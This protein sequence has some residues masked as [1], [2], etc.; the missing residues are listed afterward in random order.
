MWI[1]DAGKMVFSVQSIVP[2]ADNV[3]ISILRKQ[4]V[5]RKQFTHDQW[6]NVVVRGD[7]AKDVGVSRKVWDAIN[8][9][10]ARVFVVIIQSAYDTQS[11]LCHWLWKLTLMLKISRPQKKG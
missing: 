6:I 7:V 3:S 1:A 9:V 8:L 11:L 2:A 5:K 4:R 10:A